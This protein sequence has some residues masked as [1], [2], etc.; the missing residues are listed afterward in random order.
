MAVT[1]DDIPGSYDAQPSYPK[2]RTMSTLIAALEAH[3][4]APVGFVNGVYAEADPDALLGLKSWLDAGFEIANHTFS[5]QSARA[6]S[7]DA[8]LA[9]VRKNRAFLQGVAPDRPVRFFR[10]PYLERGNDPSQ[11]VAITQALARDGYRIANVSVDFADWGFAPAFARCFT[12]DDR[13]ALAGLRES[14][15]QN[16][17]AALYWS[18]ENSA[19]LFGRAIP[20]VLLLHAHAATAEN[21]DALLTRYEQAGV[22]W[23]TL[24][25]ALSDPAYAEPPER[26]HGDTA[27]LSEA[28]R[29]SGARIS[30]FIPRA[31]SL[32]D[33]VCR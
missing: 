10:F 1:I 4:I 12:R 8:F 21:L 20:Q 15:L 33:L 14:Y 13:H 7:V 27:L 28:M 11:R 25:Q 17:S 30:S 5:H 29:V 31:L 22:R 26:D 23:I 19:Q 16:G 24:E 6:L 9:D 3:G 32:L 18:V 2:S